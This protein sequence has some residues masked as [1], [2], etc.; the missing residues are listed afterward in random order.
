VPVPN[1]AFNSAAYKPE[2]EGRQKAKAAA[3]KKGKA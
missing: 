1:P 2:N 3:K